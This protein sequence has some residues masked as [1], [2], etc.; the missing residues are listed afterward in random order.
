[1]KESLLPKKLP[2]QQPKEK[3]EKLFDHCFEIHKLEESDHIPV[4]G[5]MLSSETNIEVIGDFNNLKDFF[6]ET[7]KLEEGYDL[8]KI[9]EQLV[10]NGVGIKEETFANLIAFQRNYDKNYPANPHAS[11]TRSNLYKERYKGKEI[12]LSDIFKA[13]IAECAEIAALAQFYLQQKCI[14][15]SYFS[16]EVLW[17]RD[18]EFGEAHSFLILKD[19]GKTY[20][21]DPTNPLTMPKGKF[22]SLY[23]TD[24]DFD[25]EVRLGQKKFVTAKNIVTGTEAFYGVGSNTNV[26]PDRH[27]V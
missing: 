13:N 26:D 25:K 11:A 1:M 2:E 8:P 17:N 12:N 23:T 9:K 24:K 15:C 10:S 5:S 19:N 27:I 16:G 3:I 18:D 6:E 22:P 4:G 21:Y 7:S 14:N 20:I